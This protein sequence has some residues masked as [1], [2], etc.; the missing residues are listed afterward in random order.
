MSCDT[1]G[2]TK[3][4]MMNYNRIGGLEVLVGHPGYPAIAVCNPHSYIAPPQTCDLSSSCPLV[5]LKSECIMA[6][7]TRVSYKYP[8]AACPQ[9][10]L[11]PSS[12]TPP[13]GSFSY[14][15]SE[16][17]NTIWHHK[18]G[19]HPYFFTSPLLDHPPSLANSAPLPLVKVVYFPLFPL[20]ITYLGLSLAWTTR[21]ATLPLISF[22]PLQFILPLN[23]PSQSGHAKMQ[24]WLCQYH[25]G[26]EASLGVQT[27][28]YH[29]AL[30]CLSALTC[31]LAPFF[32]IPHLNSMHSHVSFCPFLG[33][34]A[35]AVLSA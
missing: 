34:F 24:I 6:T 8:N 32:P 30:T 15:P 4:L 20:P 1:G 17:I 35:N 22:S 27:G 11:S 16:S 21:K 7:S 29:V 25:D 14:I 12:T 10:Q 19:C 9:I 3:W 33:I 31:A 28:Q 23:S 26:N 5:L 18:P 13:K 2:L